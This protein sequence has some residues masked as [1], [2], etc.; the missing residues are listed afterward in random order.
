MGFVAVK[1]L[2]IMMA[3]FRFSHPFGQLLLMPL[4]T[5]LVSHFSTSSASLEASLISSHNC[6]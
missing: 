5:F 2:M 6:L 3:L 1:H 4:E